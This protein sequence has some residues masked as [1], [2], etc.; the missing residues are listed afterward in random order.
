MRD[1]LYL[2]G[3][4]E[5]GSDG[6]LFD[7]TIIREITDTTLVDTQADGITQKK[8]LEEDTTDLGEGF[9][10]HDEAVLVERGFDGGITR[11][12]PLSEIPGV[13]HQRGD[14]PEPVEAETKTTLY[15]INREDRRKMVAILSHR[16]LNHYKSP[17]AMK[18]QAF[19][20]VRDG[21]PDAPSGS[22]E[23][24]QPLPGTELY[25]ASMS[26]VYNWLTKVV[27][28]RATVINKNRFG[29][30]VEDLSIRIE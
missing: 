25:P 23:H 13:D 18:G 30:G 10:V 15:P 9:L 29:S 20:P 26:Q 19:N 5:D 11:L 4:E 22:F 8:Q 16:L 24:L 7:P 12:T 17:L 6:V 27:G 14:E 21:L 3:E 2:P 28:D 1:K